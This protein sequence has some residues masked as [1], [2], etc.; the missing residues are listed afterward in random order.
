MKIHAGIMEVAVANLL[1]YRV[2][3]IV[4]NV[5]H[6]L[7]LNHECDMLALKDG[8]FTEIEIKV[9]ISDL[10]ADFKKKHEHKS[11]YITRL[12]YAVP[13]FMLD[14]ALEIITMEFGVIVVKSYGDRIIYHKASWVRKA[15]HRKQQECIPQSILNK[16]YQ[17]GCM[18]IWSLKMHNNYN[19]SKTK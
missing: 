18:R 14:K 10:K 17:L 3:T 19:K 11:K 15:R 5:S 16:F 12:V 9:S 4:P 13:E 1:N 2:Y 8:K 7:Y 6:G